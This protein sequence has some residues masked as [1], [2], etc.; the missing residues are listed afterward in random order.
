MF[1]FLLYVFCSNFGKVWKNRLS[2]VSRES[3][4]QEEQDVVTACFSTPTAVTAQQQRMEYALT[5][6]SMFK[7]EKMSLRSWV[8]HHIYEGVDHFILIDNNERGN[9]EACELKAYVESGIVTLVRDH[10]RHSQAALLN[11]YLSP[12]LS[13]TKWVLSIDMDEY[14]YARNVG[15]HGG[16]TIAQVLE[17][18]PAEVH[19]ILLPWK[20]YIAPYSVHVGDVSRA[21][22]ERRH[23]GANCNVKWVGR[24]SSVAKANIHMPTIRE[25]LLPG[26]CTVR[27]PDMSCLV[28]PEKNPII[29]CPREPMLNFPLHVNHYQTQSREYFFLSKMHRGAADNPAHENVRN[30]DYFDGANSNDTIEDAELALKRFNRTKE[31]R[32]TLDRLVCRT[33]RSAGNAPEW[34]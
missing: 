22:T 28:V 32:F 20:V 9:D 33:K 8:Q 6:I 21:I 29:T 27:L 4:A 24:G 2:L 10:S 13:R 23:M 15:K 30:W 17:S 14:V 34:C 1:L 26:N 16:L 7:M 5:V 18:V 3:S 19:V 12:F 31:D 25:S 11:Q